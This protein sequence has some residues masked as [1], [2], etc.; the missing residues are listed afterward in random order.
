MSGCGVDIYVFWDRTFMSGR[1]TLKSSFREHIVPA[2][3]EYHDE[4]S[5]YHD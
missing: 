2:D 1:L 5:I 3:E 4:R